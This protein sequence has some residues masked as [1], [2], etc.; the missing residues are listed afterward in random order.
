MVGE[1]LETRGPQIP[2]RPN[3]TSVTRGRRGALEK[4]ALV[5]L[6]SISLFGYYISWKYLDGTEITSY[7]GNMFGKADTKRRRMDWEVMERDALSTPGM[8]FQEAA[9]KYEAVYNIMKI[10]A[11]PKAGN[12]LERRHNNCKKLH[13]RM[14]S[15]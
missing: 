15:A 2:S 5:E 7:N 11:S 6:A 9:Q 13:T 3:A 4:L 12:W 10:H 14:T 1:P 8:T